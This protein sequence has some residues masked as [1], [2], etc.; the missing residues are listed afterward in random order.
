MSS[1]PHPDYP[2][3]RRQCG[4]SPSGSHTNCDCSG[5]Y[6]PPPPHPPSGYIHPTPPTPEHSPISPTGYSPTG[7]SP[8]GYYPSGYSPPP[9]SPPAYSPVSSGHSLP[10][11]SPTGYSPPARSPPG[12]SPI[13][14]STSHSPPG[15]SP[16]GFSS[17]YS[18][19]PGV[20]QYVNPPSGASYDSYGDR[21]SQGPS[22]SG[23][24]ASYYG[25]GQ[26]VQGGSISPAPT[27]PQYS[28]SGLHT[29]TSPPAADN[30]APAGN[31][32]PQASNASPVSRSNAGLLSLSKLPLRALGSPGTA[33]ARFFQGQ[34]VHALIAA[35]S[36]V[37]GVILGVAHICYKITGSTYW[38]RYEA[39][40]GG[41]EMEVREFAEQELRQ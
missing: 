22:Q 16:S 15:Y 1:Y 35:D 31:M 18:F 32:R 9:R 24:Q 40:Q 13:E 30:P 28:S 4:P 14:Y 11:R 25:K 34:K 23:P 10:Q 27:S 33:L 3:P 17:G 36:W 29:Q 41:S 2:R 21:W 5:S 8:A 39:V 38:V 7:Y 19:S 6:Y 37:M 12:C 26:P 20:G